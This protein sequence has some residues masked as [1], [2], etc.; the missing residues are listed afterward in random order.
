[1]RIA[2]PAAIALLVGGFLLLAPPQA[3]ASCKACN[4][5]HKDCRIVAQIDYKICKADCRVT[6]AGDPDG[7]HACYEA[8]CRIPRADARGDCAAERVSCN[9]VCSSAASPACPGACTGPFRQCSRGVRDDRKACMDGCK[10]TAKSERQTCR[11]TARADRDTCKELEDPGACLEMV[12]AAQGACVNAGGT[13]QAACL[14]G[15][16]ASGAA[17]VA[18]CVAVLDQC[19]AACP[20]E[21]PEAP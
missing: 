2:S 5:A 20:P 7:R 6:F 4:L 3:G 10:A 15:C 11:S 18:A 12:G 9:E 8:S 16:A 14:D 21:V 13:A 1:M 19:V 17:G